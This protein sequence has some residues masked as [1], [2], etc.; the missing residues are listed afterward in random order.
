LRGAKL[1]HEN[2]VARAIAYSIGEVRFEH[3]EMVCKGL[4]LQDPVESVGVDL[5]LE[6]DEKID[7]NDLGEGTRRL[8]LLGMAQVD[9]VKRFVTCMNGWKPD[10]GNR[11][12]ARFK[13]E[14][15]CGVAAGLT[16]DE[17]FELVYST[18]L[19]HAGPIDGPEVQAAVLSVIAYL[20]SLCEIFEYEPSAA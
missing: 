11:L 1:A 7:I 3:L 18:A 2:K 9:E 5:P 17:L 13:Q 15:F 8:I 20:F 4:G 19:E 16:G 6:I 10:F 12:A 14:Y